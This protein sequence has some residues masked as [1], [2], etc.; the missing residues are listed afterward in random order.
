MT[1]RRFT[2]RVPL[3]SS[4]TA[5][6]CCALLLLCLALP[7]LA[8]CPLDELEPPPEPSYEV[9]IRRTAFGIPHILADDMASA[10]FGMG[11]AGAQD[12]VCILADQ[13]IRVRSERSYHFGPG[14]NDEHLNSDFGMLALGV[15]SRGRD[16]LAALSEDLHAVLEGYAAGYNHYLETTTALPSPCAGASWVKPISVDDLA[17]YAFLLNLRSSALPFFEYV[18]TAAPPNAQATSG[19]SS[20]GPNFNFRDLGMGSNGWAIGKSRSATGRG[21]LLANP[22]FPWEGELRMHE[23][24]ITVPGKLNV[25]GAS[26]TGVPVITIGFNE[27][28]AWTHTVTP[29]KHFTLYR[30]QLSA[31]DPSKYIYDGETRS[32][33]SETYSVEVKIGEGQYDSRTRTF[34]RSHYGPMVSGGGLEWTDSQAFSYRDANENNFGIAQQWYAMNRAGSMDEFIDAHRT[35]HGIPWVFTIATDKEGQAV[36]LDGSR[37]PKLSDQTVAEYKQALD[38]NSLVAGIAGFGVVMLEGNTSTTEWIGLTDNG[39]IVPIDEAPQLYRDD[40]VANANDSAWIANPS[41]PLASMPYLYGKFEQP[42]SPRTRMNFT[43][44]SESSTGGASGADHKFDHQELMDVALSNRGKMA[45]LLLDAVVIRCTGHKTVDVDGELID[46]ET[47]CA[48]LKSWDT[49]LDLDSE[50]ALLWRLVLAQFSSVDL[51]DAGALF[52]TGFDAADPINTP[53][54]LSSAP[55]TG[56]DPILRKLGRAVQNLGKAG[57]SAGAKLRDTQFALKGEEKIPLH[58]GNGAEGVTNIIV[59]SDSNGT[60]LPKTTRGETIGGTSGLTTDGNYLVNYGTSFIMALAYTDE[61]PQAKAFLTYSESTDPDSPHFSDQTKAFS[62]KAWRAIRFTEQDI[63]A[64]PQ[65][66]TTELRV[67]RPRP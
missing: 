3:M 60:L 27:H 16:V 59:Y 54:T 18:A 4:R 37:T 40:Y 26:L 32:M 45:E 12:F 63:A 30:L 36:M 34:Y 15:V 38:T 20:V 13:I 46:I 58:G 57:L 31:T 14:E 33:E 1:R 52:E 56:V 39:G 65:L 67:A 11:Y 47:A 49:R 61:G 2:A 43:A 22:H 23:S 21:M 62:D 66:V 6:D 55:A 25:Y 29:A 24:H 42:L 41:A 8:G 48:V 51:A 44:L 19:S 50:G 53:H 17:A 10:G 35:H 28:V 5:R 9:T 7:C 64:D